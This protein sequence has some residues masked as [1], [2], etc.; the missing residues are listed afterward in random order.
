MLPKKKKKVVCSI[1]YSPSMTNV[2]T[3]CS[4]AEL[5]T[6]QANYFRHFLVTALSKS[7]SVAHD[8]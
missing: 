4:K 3:V 5:T 7:L 1:K 6:E 8:I 2:M